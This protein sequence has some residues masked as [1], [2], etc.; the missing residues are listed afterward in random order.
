MRARDKNH[1]ALSTQAFGGET[2]LLSRIPADFP[3]GV[4]AEDIAGQVVLPG[5]SPDTYAMFAYG[6]FMAPTIQDKDLV[7][8]RVG[9]DCKNGDIVLMNSKWGELILRRYRIK[10]DGV[11]FSS[12]NSDYT[13]FQPE[14]NLR[15]VGVV[16]DVWR[17]LKI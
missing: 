7:I 3:N 13:P 9:E 8:F 17:K 12:D 4:R 10:T 1:S 6:D 16:T 5:N 11:W 15:I 2:P 14:P